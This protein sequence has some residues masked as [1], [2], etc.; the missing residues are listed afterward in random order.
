[1]HAPELEPDHHDV[2]TDLVDRGGEPG[3]LRLLLGNGLG[4]LVV[5]QL[6][7][8]NIE[9]VKK[10]IYLKNGAM[11]S[12]LFLGIIMLLDA[13]GMHIPSWFS[14]VVTF[15]VIGY[16]YLKSVKAANQKG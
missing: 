1:L 4:A 2:A 7:V 9:R 12:I 14:P 8:G 10:Y 15:A 3:D 16:F 13:F 6:T 11:Y 5:R